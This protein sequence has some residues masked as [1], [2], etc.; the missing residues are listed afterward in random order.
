MKNLNPPVY[1]KNEALEEYI[2]LIEQIDT[3]SDTFDQLYYHVAKCLWLD[4]GVQQ[5]YSRSNEYHLIGCAK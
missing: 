2:N 1:L 3:E 5:S 4:D